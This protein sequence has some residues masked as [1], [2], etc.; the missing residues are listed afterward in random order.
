MPISFPA[1]GEL[2]QSGQKFRREILAAV[3]LELKPLIDAHMTARFGVQ[4]KET[5]GTLMNINATSPYLGE[6]TGVAD[7]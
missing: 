2:L 3:Y 7:F 4:G 5:V 6:L 1:Q